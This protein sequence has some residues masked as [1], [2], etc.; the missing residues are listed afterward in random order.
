MELYHVTFAHTKD[1][2][3]HKFKDGIDAKLSDGN[4]QGAGFY[5]WKEPPLALHHAQNF[6]PEREPK[7][8]PYFIIVQQDLMPETFDIDY[9]I[10]GHLAIGFIRKNID[11]LKERAQQLQRLDIKINDKK[12]KLMSGEEFQLQTLTYTN[13][14]SQQSV[15]YAAENC[16]SSDTNIGKGKVL[17]KIM[18]SVRSL[19]KD[20]YSQ[21]ISEA[22]P[23]TRAVKYIGLN[24]LQPTL[25]LSEE[26][27][28]GHFPP[29]GITSPML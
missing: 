29:K 12:M 23:E 6:A 25:I 7:E 16:D 15:S 5:L 17:S 27:F 28:R 26:E 22:L 3:L 1:D 9:E 11:F 20:F 19:D 2:V 10:D 21:F 24:K 14:G 18:A 13:E 8:S 4:G